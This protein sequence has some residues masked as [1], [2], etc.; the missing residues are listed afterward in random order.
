MQTLNKAIVFQEKLDPKEK[1]KAETL[2]WLNVSIVYKEM[3]I[4]TFLRI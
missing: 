3:C 1:E 2:E 4:R